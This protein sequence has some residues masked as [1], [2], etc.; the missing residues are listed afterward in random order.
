MRCVVLGDDHHAARVAVEPM[1]DPRAQ[2]AADPAEVLHVK[3]QRVDH[4]AVGVAGSGMDDQSGRFVD[5]H[6]V[7]VFVDHGE[8][9]V[10]RDE[11]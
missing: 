3:E 8:R 9:K 4:R 7:V 1:H 6:D 5:D 2:L 11:L 10:L